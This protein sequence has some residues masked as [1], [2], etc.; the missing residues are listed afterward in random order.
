M[1]KYSKV[2]LIISSL[3]ETEEKGGWKGETETKQSEI[4]A[5]AFDPEPVDVAR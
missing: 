2:K 5:N 1:Q 3:W 4:S